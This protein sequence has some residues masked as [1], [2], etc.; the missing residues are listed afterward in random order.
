[1]GGNVGAPDRLDFTVMGAAVNRTARIEDL[2]KALGRNLL[3]SAEFA[4][5]IEAPTVSL[6][7]H[8]MKG[9]KDPQEVFGLQEGGAS[10]G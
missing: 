3:M 10:A 7:R 1:V 8:A 6:G 5:Q 4:R 9:V 2:T